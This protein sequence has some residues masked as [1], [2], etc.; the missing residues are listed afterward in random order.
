VAWG[1]LLESIYRTFPSWNSTN[2]VFV[3]H[4]PAR[5]SCNP[6]ANTIIATPFYVS[7]LTKLGDDE[8]F[9]KTSLWPKLNALLKLADLANFERCCKNPKYKNGSPN[10][11][12]IMIMNAQVV[13]CTLS[14]VRGLMKH[15]VQLGHCPL[16]FRR[17]LFLIIL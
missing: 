13:M 7:Q 17:I 1:C 14:K 6:E 3:D 11:L 2:T 5:V 15:L 12:N 9:V 16:T 4:K 8:Q 10:I